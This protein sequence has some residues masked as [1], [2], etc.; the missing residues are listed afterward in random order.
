M[1]VLKRLMT[2]K[3][4]YFV[5]EMVN[6]IFLGGRPTPFS[7]FFDAMAGQQSIRGT[8]LAQ[9]EIIVL[10]LEEPVLLYHL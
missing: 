2:L 4:D 6:Y 8:Y 9:L 3:I 7:P 1:L 5:Q 10:I